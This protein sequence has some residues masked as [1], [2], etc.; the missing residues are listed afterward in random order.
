MERRVGGQEQHRVQVLA[1]GLSQG[2]V[3]DGSSGGPT[4]RLGV[5]LKSSSQN[6][7]C[8]WCVTQ[9]WTIRNNRILNVGYVAVVAANPSGG[10]GPAIHAKRITFVNNI[11]DRLNQDRTLGR[12]NEPARWPASGGDVADF[13]AEHNTLV[14][15]SGMSPFRWANW[16]PMARAVFANNLVTRGSQG[17]VGCGNDPASCSAEGVTSLTTYAPSAVFTGNALI[18]ANASLY[19]GGNLFRARSVAL[20]S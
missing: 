19:P 4:G 17:V 7:A 16:G 6:G 14:V 3:I 13:V 18:G 2:N 8:T 12:H 1:A 11:A 9:D 20:T 15:A 10:G 5:N